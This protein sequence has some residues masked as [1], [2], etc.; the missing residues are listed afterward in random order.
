MKDAHLHKLETVSR[1][2]L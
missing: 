1:I 2:T